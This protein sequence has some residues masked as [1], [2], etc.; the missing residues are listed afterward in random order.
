[1]GDEA[2]DTL[3]STKISDD[4]KKNYAKVMA[5]LNSFFLSQ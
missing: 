4:E 1:M 2:E 3:V 5:K